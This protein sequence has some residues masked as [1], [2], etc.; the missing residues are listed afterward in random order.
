MVPTTISEWFT[1]ERVLI[2]CF[3]EKKNAKSPFS[4]LV[5]VIECVQM[6]KNDEKITFS[7]P[8]LVRK[9]ANLHRNHKNRKTKF[10]LDQGHVLGNAN[11]D[12]GRQISVFT[13]S[14]YFFLRLKMTIV[15]AKLTAIIVFK[16]HSHGIYEVEWHQYDLR[17]EL[18]AYGGIGSHILRK[19]DLFLCKSSENQNHFVLLILGYF[20]PYEVLK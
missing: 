16:N 13:F 8:P 6:Q 10:I 9:N 3:P 17:K 11:F 5:I 12:P 14:Q 4:V 18:C 20:S 2:R 15:L 7:L 1:Y 19:T